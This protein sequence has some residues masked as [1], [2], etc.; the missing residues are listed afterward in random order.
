MSWS[1]L[2]K[3]VRIYRICAVLNELGWG[4]FV[5]DHVVPIGSSRVCGLNTHDNL[6]IITEQENYEKGH[7]WW[8]QMWPIEEERDEAL[9][10]QARRALHFTM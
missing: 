2:A 7:W 10:E 5:V 9:F 4:K 6:Q 1:D 3:V 8:P